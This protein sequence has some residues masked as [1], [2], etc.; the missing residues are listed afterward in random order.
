MLEDIQTTNEAIKGL[1][2]LA[3]YGVLE[4]ALYFSSIGRPA[5]QPARAAHGRASN[6]GPT[7]RW[8]ED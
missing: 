3:M 5:K 8:P 2:L 1:M 7:D 6:S 4:L